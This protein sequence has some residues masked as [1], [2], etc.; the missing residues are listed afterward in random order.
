MDMARLDEIKDVEYGR[1]SKEVQIAS[2]SRKVAPM[3]TKKP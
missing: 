3:P 1:K 2:R